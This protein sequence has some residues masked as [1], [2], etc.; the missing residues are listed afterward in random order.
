MLIF[1]TLNFSSHLLHQN[2][3]FNSEIRFSSKCSLQAGHSTGFPFG[4][5]QRSRD[6][7]ILFE[8]VF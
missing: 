7:F 2:V 3:P 8:F 1:F 6:L 4:Y 5:G